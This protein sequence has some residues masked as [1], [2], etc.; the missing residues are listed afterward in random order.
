MTAPPDDPDRRA[1]DRHSDERMARVRP[2]AWRNPNPADLYDLVV[3]GGGPAG[4]AAAREAIEL[5]ARVALVERRA[6][7]GTSLHVGCAPSKAL[8]RTA[9]LYAD[10]R[11]AEH[12]GARAPTGVDLDFPQAMERARREQARLSKQWSAQR[13]AEAGVDI[14]FGDG[15]FSGA[16]RA[17][18]GDRVLRFRRA[19]VATGARAKRPAI[20]GLASAGYLTNETVFDL[21]ARPR[22]L[23]VVGGGPL[24]CELAQAFRRLGCEVILAQQDPSFL[25]GEERDAAQILGNA[26]AKDGVE[27]HLNSEVASVRADDGRKT[28][29]IVTAGHRFSVIVDEVLVGV[30][31]APNIA[32]LGLE[33]AGVDWDR[34][35]GIHVDDMLRTGNRAIYAA[36]DVCLDH[37]F[38]HTAEASARIA[39][40]N[41]LSARRERLSRLVIPWCTYTDPE[42]AHVG[43]Y[44]REAR[45]RRIPVRTF[46]VLMHDVDRAVLDGEDL[47]FAKIHVREGTD[48]ILGATLVARHAGEMINGVSLAISAG[49]GL[50][51]LARVVHAYPTQ[52]EAIKMAADA[53]VRSCGARARSPAHLRTP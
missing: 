15:R 52:A 38:T 39:T 17:T 26:L 27:I 35:A 32:G 28:V 18:V 19:I 22:R 6:L 42:I 46:T 10:M 33:A 53:Y 50:V 3:I 40:R 31:R 20:E 47:G 9:R 12:F 43:L 29:E 34:R 14:F 2:L 24:G 51:E 48:Q 5:G 8:I 25:P 36:G 7:G 41:A 45:E 21:S 13:L 11:D 4:V 30:G 44:V 37:K 23:M 49:I 16:R 1:T